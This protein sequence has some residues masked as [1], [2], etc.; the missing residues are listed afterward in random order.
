M[1]DNDTS[2]YNLRIKKSVFL[3]NTLFFLVAVA[4][5]LAETKLLQKGFTV[6]TSISPHIRDPVTGTYGFLK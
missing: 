5:Y 1:I 4:I 6:L 2:P 3:R